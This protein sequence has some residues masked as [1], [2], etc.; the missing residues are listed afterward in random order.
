MRAECQTSRGL[1]AR[2]LAERD[3]TTLNDVSKFDWEGYRCCAVSTDVD[4]ITKFWETLDRV[5]ENNVR[6]IR[7]IF[8]KRAAASTKKG[9]TLPA[10]RQRH[11]NRCMTISCQSAISGKC[12]SSNS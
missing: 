10:K 7:M 9:G 8:D 2:Y 12:S 3:A 11:R 4:G 6:I 5:G 1:M